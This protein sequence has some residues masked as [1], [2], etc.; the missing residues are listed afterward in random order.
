MSKKKP[1]KHTPLSVASDVGFV[2]CLFL[3]AG[4]N[5]ARQSGNHDEQV[6]MSST[7]TEQKKVTTL[8][9][10]FCRIFLFVLIF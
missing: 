7:M 1:R 2:F 5:G 6:R 10:A 4:D 3:C 9:G 8:Q